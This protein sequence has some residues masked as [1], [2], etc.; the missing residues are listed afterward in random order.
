MEVF[1]EEKVYDEKLSPLMKQIIEICKEHKIPMLAV[2]VYEND[3]NGD[4]NAA[5]T[6]LNFGDDDRFSDVLHQAHRTIRGGG[7]LAITTITTGDLNVQG[8]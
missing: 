8:I 2:F 7:N 5:T 3:E 4:Q 1:S 6:Y